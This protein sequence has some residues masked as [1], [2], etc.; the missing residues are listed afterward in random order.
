MYMQYMSTPRPKAN[1]V[2]SR[3]GNALEGA[4]CKTRGFDA[5]KA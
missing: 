4:V 5:I 1:D 3:M 2:Y